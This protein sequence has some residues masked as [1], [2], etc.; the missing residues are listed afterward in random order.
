MPNPKT[1]TVTMDIKKAIKDIREGKIDF[2]PDKKWNSSCFNS[3]GFP[4]PK[5]DL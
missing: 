2:K 4:C 3:K 5:K 1:G